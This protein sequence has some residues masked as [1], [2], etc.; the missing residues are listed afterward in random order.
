VRPD[1]RGGTIAIDLPHGAA[2][3]RA[4][5]VREILCDYRPGGGVRLSPHF[6]TRD[7]ELDA[8]IEAMEEIL[9]TNAWRDHVDARSDVT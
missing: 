1:E 5:K 3:S 9:R 2:V 6:Y 8:A 7:D 4:L